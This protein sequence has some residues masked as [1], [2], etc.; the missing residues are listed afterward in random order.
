MQKTESGNAGLAPRARSTFVAD[1]DPFCAA[2]CKGDRPTHQ[3]FLPVGSA[4][5]PI[6]A[7]MISASLLRRVNVGKELHI[8]GAQKCDGGGVPPSSVSVHTYAQ[9][10]FAIRAWI[11]VTSAR[12]GDNH[13][14]E[15]CVSCLKI[16][17]AQVLG[18]AFTRSIRNHIYGEW[19]VKPSQHDRLKKT[20]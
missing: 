12:R 13:M 8:D 6:K 1:S 14:W 4:P 5:A 10:M 16:G 15:R 20:R 2:K 18:G 3:S 19:L 11:R 7:L 9:E 17:L